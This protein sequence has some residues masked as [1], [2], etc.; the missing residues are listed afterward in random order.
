MTLRPAPISAGYGNDGE[1]GPE[2]DERARQRRFR[3]P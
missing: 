2:Q 3:D 1:T